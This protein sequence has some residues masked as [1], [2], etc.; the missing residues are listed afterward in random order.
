MPTT[1]TTHDLEHY[2]SIAKDIAIEAGKLI[3]AKREQQ[4]DIEFKD[5]IELVTD[6]DTA[7][8]EFICTQL[9]KHFP[10]H[11]IMA[12][13][14]QP[15]WQEQRDS[16]TPL[17]IIDPIDGTVN[18]AHHHYMVGVSIGLAL[19]D[20]LVLGVVHN[21]FLNETF[22]AI[23][24]KGAYLQNTKGSHKIQC[25]QEPTMKRALIATGFP[26]D[27]SN[28]KPLVNRVE[29]I[30]NNCAD[31]RRAGSAALDICWTACGR[32]DGYY[33]SLKLWDFAAAQVIAIEAGCSYGHFEALNPQQN[34]VFHCDDILVANPSLF[35]TLK[36]LL[37]S[38][39][40]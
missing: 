34:P 5:G 10:D 3:Q 11:D 6:A 8:D 29:M 16:N 27:K 40:Q 36:T 21:P 32:L 18:Y 13:E 14:S 24:G 30:L 31:I 22:T 35:N 37:K 26:Y 17:W 9:K 15:N 38:A 39:N 7:C 19:S 4:L 12:E 1:I 25:S 2:L 33:E 20:D 23:K 28:L